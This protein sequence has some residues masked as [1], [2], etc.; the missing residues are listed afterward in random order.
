VLGAF[1]YPGERVLWRYQRGQLWLGD[2][3]ISYTDTGDYAVRGQHLPVAVLTSE[4]TASSGEAVAIAFRGRPNARSFGE[5]TRG[6]T[7]A[8]E[9]FELGDQATIHL[10]VA[11]FADRTG[12]A[13]NGPIAPNVTVAG[14]AAQV[15]A[16]A[17]AWIETYH[18]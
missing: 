5:P 11:L 10:T 16:T 15:Q 6:L 12:A 4:Q 1:N 7:S 17:A 9:S 8:N 3:P 13:Y 14:G 18:A 2:T